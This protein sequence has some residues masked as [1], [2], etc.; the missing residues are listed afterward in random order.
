MATDII[1]KGFLTT[2]LTPFGGQW[3]KMK[4]IIVN[5]LLSP[6]QH[7]WLKNKRN[8]EADDL[9]F[10]VYNKCKNINDD[11]LVNVRIVAQNYCYNL[12]RK[13]IFNSRYFGEAE[14]VDHVDAVFTL[15]KY[16]F[17]FC[18]SDYIP[19][20]RGL[21]IDGHERKVKDAMS[22]VN[23]YNDPIIERR[24]EK[25]KD[26]SKSSADAE[27]LLDILISLKDANNKPLLTS[28]EIKAQALELVLGG[29]DNPSCAAEFAI[30]EMINQPDLLQRA[31]EEL[32]NVVGKQRLVQE[33][34]IP[35]LN[36][37]KACAREAFRLHSVR[38]FNLPHVAMDDIEVG[39]YMIPKGSHVLLSKQ[40]HLKNDG[41]MVVLAEP[42]LKFISFSTG[43]RGCPGNVLG[44]TMTIML[45]GRLLHGFNWSGPPNVSTIDLLKY[46]NGDRYLGGPLVAIAK[47]RLAVELYHP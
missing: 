16:I 24:I 15:L 18:V 9:M 11:G 7:Q 20:L 23:K 31:I 47:P 4:K 34:D 37:V 10:Y 39:I 35:N 12:M 30:A 36:Y 32:D 1:T 8:E 22:I 17:L 19:L 3:K 21:D 43:R 41:S 2:A 5:E 14:E 25:W 40:G 46:S 38:I 33:S 6:H 28:D 29:V 13:L 27:D 42:D 45:L 44:T 26:G